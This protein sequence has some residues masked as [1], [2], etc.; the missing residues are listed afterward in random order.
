M[1]AAA[2]MAT[3]RV[4]GAPHRARAGSTDGTDIGSSR[5]LGRQIVSARLRALPACGT[6]RWTPAAT[7]AP[8]QRV[9]ARGQRGRQ[10]DFPGWLHGGN[11][12]TEPGS[13]TVPGRARLGS[14]VFTGPAQLDRLESALTGGATEEAEP[15]GSTSR[16]SVGRVN[17]STDANV[18]ATAHGSRGSPRLTTMELPSGAGHDAQ[19]LAAVRQRMVFVPSDG[20]IATPS[21]H[22][23]G[24]CSTAPTSC[25]TRRFSWRGP[26]QSE[27]T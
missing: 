16:S 25:S 14:S 15:A 13:S 19:S 9:R 24:H 4:P 10:P 17:C 20:G 22:T 6:S 11:I 26:R 1:L 12:A 8:R 18:R 2:G 7:R 23:A 27:V 5:D 21:E 3:L